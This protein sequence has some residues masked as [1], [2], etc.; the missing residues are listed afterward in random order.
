MIFLNAR[1]IVL[2]ETLAHWGSKGVE[3]GGLLWAPFLP[4]S[5]LSTLGIPPLGGVS[6]CFA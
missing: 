3:R 2:H 6:N 5:A 1:A 4:D